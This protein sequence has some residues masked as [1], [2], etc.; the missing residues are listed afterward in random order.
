MNRLVLKNL[1]FCVN[2]NSVVKNVV[3]SLDSREVHVLM[4]PNGSG[5]SS[6]AYGLMS[7]P[8]YSVT[9][10]DIIFNGTSLVAEA[11]DKRARAGFF[12]AVQ[13]PYEIPGVSVFSFLMHAYQACKGKITSAEMKEKIQ[14]ALRTVGLDTGFMDRAVNDGFSGGEKKRLE[15]LQ[16]LVL[17]PSVIILDEI[18]S[19]LD[20][21]AL[22]IVRSSI[23]SLK[24]KNPDTIFLI[25]T[26]SP[27]LARMLT[28]D[29]VH[30]MAGG[31]IV[32]S[33][34]QALIA[35]IETAGYEQYR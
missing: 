29:H 19:G 31:T 26:H 9:S 7:H 33:G 34:G 21:D 25:I 18:D 12:L 1:S 16:M 20:I 30:I 5:K 6:L 24:N 3:L 11:V 17:E 23:Q 32:R 27:V 22:E 2:D 10:G 15:L 28:V 13:H 8:R 14:S 35:D 4:G